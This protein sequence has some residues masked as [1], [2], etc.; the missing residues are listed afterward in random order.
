[1][2]QVHDIEPETQY[3]LL[4]DYCNDSDVD[5]RLREETTGV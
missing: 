5:V 2:K 4:V 3:L 1:M